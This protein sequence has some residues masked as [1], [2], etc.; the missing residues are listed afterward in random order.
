M[1]KKIC[2]NQ[3]TCHS[4]HIHISSLLYFVHR[5]KMP[6]NC[7]SIEQISTSVLFMY[8][9]LSKQLETE[10]SITARR[11]TWRAQTSLAK[12]DYYPHPHTALFRSTGFVAAWQYALMN[13]GPW[14]WKAN[15]L[16]FT[17][18]DPSIKFHGDLFI[19]FWVMLLTNRQRNKWTLPKRR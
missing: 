16:P 10:H 6:L 17:T 9:K 1:N 12:A 19:T 2:L 14:W 13:V 4:W 3:T 18:T 11:S 15:L 5:V 8:S 7:S